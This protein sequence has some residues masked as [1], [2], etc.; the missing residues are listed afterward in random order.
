MSG[1]SPF[2]GWAYAP[3]GRAHRQRT[4]VWVSV[5]L[6]NPDRT[7]CHDLPRN[8]TEVITK[9]GAIPWRR[10]RQP[11]T[12]MRQPCKWMKSLAPTAREVN[13]YLVGLGVENS[14]EAL[15]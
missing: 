13:A 5:G 10:T 9:E 8:D 3:L 2:F 1:F 4:H 15:R 14:P 12:S 7:G 11:G 6:N